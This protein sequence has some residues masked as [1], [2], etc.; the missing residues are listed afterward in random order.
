MNRVAAC[1]FV[2]VLL[3]TAA[4]LRGQAPASRQPDDRFKADLLLIVAH[5]DDDTLAGTYLAKVLEEGKRVAVVYGTS[6]DSGGNQLGPERAASLGVIRQIEGRRGLATLG[7]SNVW[8]LSGHDT[9]GQDPVRSLANWDHGRVLAEAVR[10]V[11]LTRPEVILTWLPMQVAGENHGDHQAASVIAI[12]AFDLAGDPTAFPEQ[13]AAPT[14]MFESL[15]EG[16]R[17]WQPKKIY[18]MSDAIDTR[19]MD[20]HG[21][22]YSVTATSRTG[23]KY[24]EYAYHQLQSHVTQYRAELDQLAAA[25]PATREKMVTEAPPGDALLN[26]LR[27]IRGRSLVGGN[28]IGDVFEGVAAAPAAFDAPRPNRDGTTGGVALGLG[29]PWAFYHRFWQAH[30]IAELGAIDLHEIGPVNGGATVR[31]P[32]IVVNHTSATQQVSV[33]SRLPEGWREQPR[34]ATLTVQ[35]HDEVEFTSGL[36]VQTPAKGGAV[37]VVYELAGA[38]PLTVRLVV[39]PG[40]NPLPQ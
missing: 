6:G 25:D 30:G 23:A 15:L 17:P 29:G 31:V 2:S 39:T 4:P 18:F 20:G 40:G 3:L 16:L 21:P 1:L 7:I 26:P 24:W 22:S 27:F 34:P 28:P 11:R 9:P 19:F 12:E 14:Q 10:L 37:D 8:F 5:P 32:L 35:A 36:I 38:A 13:L 33:T